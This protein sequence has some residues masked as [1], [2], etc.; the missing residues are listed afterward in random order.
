MD[1]PEVACLMDYR[2]GELLIRQ[3][4]SQIELT[5]IPNNIFFPTPQVEKYSRQVSSL[6]L[7]FG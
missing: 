3:K 7:Y 1:F 6:L 4:A 2:R 5:H